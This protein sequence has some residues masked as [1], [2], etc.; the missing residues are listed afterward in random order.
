MAT[1]ATD[2]L[3]LE[4][5]QQRADYPGRL[6]SGLLDYVVVSNS[7]AVTVFLNVWGTNPAQAPGLAAALRAGGP[8]PLAAGF[9]GTVPIG[10]YAPS[11]ML[12]ASTGTDATGDP[13]APVQVT[14]FWEA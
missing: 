2:R 5:T 13:T 11:V 6:P 1:T 7:T 14:P 9:A 8:I 4:A 3:A 12:S 10:L